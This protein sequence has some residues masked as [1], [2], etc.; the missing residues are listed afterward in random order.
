MCDTPTARKKKEVVPLLSALCVDV[1]CGWVS[2]WVHWRGGVGWRERGPTPFPPPREQKLLCGSWGGGKGGRWGER[3][4]WVAHV[5][6][7]PC[8]P[9]WVCKAW[10]G[11]RG[12]H[13][14]APA[15]PWGNP[16]E[17]EGQRKID[18]PVGFDFTGM[19][20]ERTSSGGVGGRSNVVWGGRGKGGHDRRATGWLCTPRYTR[21]GCT[22][23][24]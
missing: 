2:G 20:R 16:K 3:G 23:C 5:G 24:V 12:G 11:G 17:E 6:V 7:A 10:G 19:Q 14:G 9:A 13:Q 1:P 8:L 15:A 21:A 22:H 18:C 4:E